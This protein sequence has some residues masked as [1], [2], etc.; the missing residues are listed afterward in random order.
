MVGHRTTLDIKNALLFFSAFVIIISG[1]FQN[2]L[3]HLGQLNESY[4]EIDEVILF[5]KVLEVP[6]K[7][8]LII[9]T[10]HKVIIATSSNLKFIISLEILKNVT[11]DIV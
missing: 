5:T 6:C 8:T 11:K 10:S 4:Q 1:D 9:K 7:H 2:G 3:Y